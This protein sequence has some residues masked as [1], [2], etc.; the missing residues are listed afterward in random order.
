MSLDLLNRL[1]STT[2]VDSDL[3]IV[4]NNNSQS[5]NNHG[6]KTATNKDINNA[7]NNN[8]NQPNKQPLTKIIQA[9]F[10]EVSIQTHST[11]QYSRT[12]KRTK[13]THGSIDSKYNTET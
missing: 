1:D 3:L 2:I 13:N 7:G 6:K 11:K 5:T 12:H 10:S 8:R 4:Q 9:L